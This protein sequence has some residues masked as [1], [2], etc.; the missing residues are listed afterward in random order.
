M[1]SHHRGFDARPR[2]RR[3]ISQIYTLISRE[4][5]TCK[6]GVVHLHLKYYNGLT[7]FPVTVLRSVNLVSNGFGI[8]AESMIKTLKCGCELVE[9]TVPLKKRNFGKSK[10]LTFLSLMKIS[11]D[12]IYILKT[13][14]VKSLNNR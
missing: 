7:V 1:T 11:R 2:I 13:S 10:A 9:L 3:L 6:G 12:L 5:P 4:F 8:F 14:S